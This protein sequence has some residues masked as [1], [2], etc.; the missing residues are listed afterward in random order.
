MVKYAKRYFFFIL[1]GLISFW[2]AKPIQA[3][4]DLPKLNIDASCEL[5]PGDHTMSGDYDH[6]SSP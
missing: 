1:M 6:Y 5:I 2:R 3:W 4:P